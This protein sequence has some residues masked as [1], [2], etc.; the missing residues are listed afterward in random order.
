MGINIATL[1]IL[2]ALIVVLSLMTRVSIISTT[3]L[4]I[5]MNGASDRAGDRARTGLNIESTTGGG[6]NLTVQVKNTGLTSVFDYDHV[7]FIVDYIDTGGTPVIARLTYTEGALGDNQW[8][9]TSITPD[10]FQP[11]A[12]NPD[13]TVRLDAKL[14]PAQQ[15]DTAATVAVVTPNGVAATSTFTSKGFF[16]LTNA[17]DISLSITGSWQDIPLSAHV[18]AGT[19]GAV[20]EVVHTGTTNAISGV[21]RGKPDTRNYM[22]D[23]LFE[24]IEGETHRWQMVQLDSNLFIQGYIENTEIDFKLRGYTSGSDPSYFDTPA[25]IA[26]ATLNEWTAVDVSAYVDADADGVILLVDSQDGGKKKFGIRE[27][28]GSFPDPTTDQQ[29]A[30]YSNTM[31]LVGIDVLNKFEAYIQTADIKIFLVGQTK[32]SVVF[33]MDDI[34]VGDPT[35]G[36]WQELDADDSGIPIGING[37]FFRVEKTGAGAAKAGFRHGDSTDDWNGDLERNTH[38]LAGTGVRTDSVWDEYLEDADLNVVIAAYTKP[39]TN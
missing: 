29:L 36:S 38:L 3:A 7:D 15:A 13:E 26:P 6:S 19:S 34:A 30:G 31:Y 28:G 12:W 5:T 35:L 39:L 37:L 11:G 17:I 25:E 23:L 27:N 32:G 10:N 1:I 8:K 14:V 24:E 9:R 18:P 21:V 16:W 4:G 22:F 2:A 20:V 33:Y